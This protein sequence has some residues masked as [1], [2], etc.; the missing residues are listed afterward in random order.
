MGNANNRPVLESQIWALLPSNILVFSKK[1]QTETQSINSQHTD[2]HKWVKHIFVVLRVC[3]LEGSVP[4]PWGRRMLRLTGSCAPGCRDWARLSSWMWAGSSST[5]TEPSSHRTCLTSST[6]RRQ[7]TAAWRSPSA[8]CCFR[9]WRRRRRRDGRRWFE[10]RGRAAHLSRGMSHP[11]PWE[12]GETGETCPW[13]PEEEG[14][15]HRGRRHPFVSGPTRGV[16]SHS[17][18]EGWVW[19]GAEEGERPH[20]RRR[21][22][23]CSSKLY[24]K[25]IYQGQT[26]LNHRQIYWDHVGLQ[27]HT[28]TQTHRLILACG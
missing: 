21:H 11:L 5:L 13:C 8:T 6:W 14:L 17:W 22:C 9:Y 2:L 1:H 25:R 20:Y 24:C 4:T 18:A 23:D 19:R 15:T 28:H 26:T 10:G 12:T 16:G 7:V 27:W 3:C